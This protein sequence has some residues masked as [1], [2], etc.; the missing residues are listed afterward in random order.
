MR[1]LRC[2]IRSSIA[3]SRSSTVH[4]PD[5]ALPDIPVSAA[6][7]SLVR[8][9][10]GHDVYR[11]RDLRQFDGAPHLPRRINFKATQQKSAV[12]GGIGYSR[13]NFWFRHPRLRTICHTSCANSLARTRWSRA[14]AIAS[15]L[16]D[17]RLVLRERLVH[18]APLLFTCS[19]SPSPPTPLPRAARG[20][21]EKSVCC[22]R[23][24]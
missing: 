14:N 15:G 18:H 10:N 9:D 8:P 6:E 2:S 11:A 4:W 24:R 23:L 21:G 12:Y 7:C 19:Q 20:R 22:A 1:G 5:P 16:R 13:R 17:D 3:G